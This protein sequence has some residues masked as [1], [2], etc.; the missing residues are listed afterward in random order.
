[1]EPAAI[2]LGPLRRA[3][4]RLAEGLDL[5]TREPENTLQRDGVIPRFEFTYEFSHRTLRRM[6]ESLAPD[7]QAIRSLSFEDLIRVAGEQGL[8]DSTWR[9][10]RAYRHARTETSHT[11]DETRAVKVISMLPTFLLDA[12]SLLRKMEA[13]CG[14]G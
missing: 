6:L 3:I 13:R 14:G 4:E 9:E 10:W 1:M 11:Y 8:L 2:E 7:P 12:R 5:L